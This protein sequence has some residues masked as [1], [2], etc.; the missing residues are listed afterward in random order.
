M[1]RSLVIA[2]IATTMI[3]T[4][5]SA[6]DT[7][8]ATQSQPA[9]PAQAAP[10]RVAPPVMNPPQPK[11]IKPNSPTN[12]TAVKATPGNKVAPKAPQAPLSGK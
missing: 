8:T 9:S 11:K 6:Q 10:L 2:L 7:K 5:L 4:G 3:S 12:T 1:N